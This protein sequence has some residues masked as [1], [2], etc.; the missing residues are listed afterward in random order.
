MRFAPV[1]GPA[2]NLIPGGR[3]E[4]T[5]SPWRPSPGSGFGGVISLSVNASSCVKNDKLRPWSDVEDQAVGSHFCKPC[6]G[7]TE[8]WRGREIERGE[9]WARTSDAVMKPSSAPVGSS[10]DEPHRVC[11]AVGTRDPDACPETEIPSTSDSSM[12]SHWQICSYQ[13]RL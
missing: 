13:D 9:N 8:E 7:G 3:P 10:S 6:L 12:C 2:L 1:A 4:S 11:I 5:L